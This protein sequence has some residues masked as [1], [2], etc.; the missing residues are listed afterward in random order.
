M[1][2][3]TLEDNV[4]ASSIANE[5]GIDYQQHA[6]ETLYQLESLVQSTLGHM[7]S[8]SNM[9]ECSNIARIL[10]PL[11]EGATCTTAVQGS[12]WLFC[13]MLAISILALIMLSTRAALFN[14]IILPQHKNR[15]EKEFEEYK[16][17]MSGFYDV[18]R[19]QLSSVKGGKLKHE[20]DEPTKGY[21][22][23]HGL[24]PSHSTDTGSTASMS[25]TVCS[26]RNFG[27]LGSSSTT[28]DDYQ[29]KDE[30]E[31]SYQS[32]SSERDSASAIT[33]PSYI[34]GNLSTRL[35]KQQQRSV[36]S[37]LPENFQDEGGDECSYQSSSSEEDSSSAGHQNSVITSLS[38]IAG[39]ISTRLR[40]KHQHQQRSQS[41]AVLPTVGP[42][43]STG[44][45]MTMSNNMFPPFVH[46]PHA[47]KTPRRRKPT[48]VPGTADI[49]H[50]ASYKKCESGISM[51]LQRHESKD[52]KL[53]SSV[54]YPLAPQKRIKNLG[55]TNCASK[56]KK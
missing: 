52:C 17:F 43:L 15:R 4:V 9:T 27:E 29:E 8:I 14:V 53:T 40:K 38:H 23:H 18:S 32:S 56:M 36:D 26:K 48:V 33:S 2:V 22:H 21:N 12:T 34:V 1:V 46:S 11:L 5:C 50:I 31:Y 39:N 20:R 10:D 42:D 55:R 30:D 28:N 16:N 47:F 7:E 37:D 45:D 6:Y 3:E 24:K 49:V 19:W 51:G 54:S 35:H 25:P 41:D 44:A 13:S